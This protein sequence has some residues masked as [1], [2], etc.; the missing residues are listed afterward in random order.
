MSSGIP[1]G[2]PILFGF[3]CIIAVFGLISFREYWA[4][5]GRA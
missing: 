3:V 5:C 1:G 2:I 4:G